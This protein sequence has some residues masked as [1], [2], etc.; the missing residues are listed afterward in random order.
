[1]ALRHLRDMG[2]D[3]EQVHATAGFLQAYANT[4]LEELDTV[5]GDASRQ[6]G[7]P[8]DEAL[9]QEP[10]FS[11]AADAATALREAGQWLLYSEPARA[12]SLLYRAGTLFLELRQPFGAYLMEIAASGRGEPPYRDMLRAVA[13]GQH[14][15]ELASTEW[16]ALRH[17]QQQAYLMLA[18]TG[19]ESVGH[20]AETAGTVLDASPHATGV[21]PVGALGTPIRRL[22]DVAAHLLARRPGSPEVIAGHLADMAYRYAEAM[23]LAQVNTHL[24]R[25]A[26]APVDVGDVDVAGVA[27][28]AAHRFGADTLL[29]T[30]QQTGVSPERHPIAMA[31]I[32][33]GAAMAQPWSEEFEANDRP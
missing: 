9:Q 28:L 20:L 4:C 11:I 10:A 14:G 33:A 5:L 25:H 12:R 2:L 19:S 8:R 24:W 27:A 29:R 23:S 15:D 6:G 30:V 32:E 26:A 22:W 17:P 31:P 18:V 13:G 21:V 7:K 16:P 1:L 3:V